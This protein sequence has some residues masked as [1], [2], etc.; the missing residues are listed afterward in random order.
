MIYRTLS[1]HVPGSVITVEE[2]QQ[3]RNV[4]LA[5]GN[6]IEP[7]NSFLVVNSQ[8]LNDLRSLIT[9]AFTQFYL[10]T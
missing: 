3:D 6:Q 10:F 4:E 2:I 5:A 9:R 8:E 7:D 1:N